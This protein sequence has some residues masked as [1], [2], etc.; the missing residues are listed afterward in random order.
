MVWRGNRGGSRGGRFS[1]RRGNRGRGSNVTR[2]SEGVS[3]P[4]PRLLETDV[5]IT[6]YLRSEAGFHG[7]IKSRYLSMTFC[8]LYINTVRSITFVCVFRYSDFHV[9]EISGDGTVAK[10]TDISVPVPP[11]SKSSEIEDEELNILNK[12]DTEV[13]SVEQ[14]DQI[15]TAAMAS[16]KSPEKVEV[17][18]TLKIFLFEKKYFYF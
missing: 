5:G 8:I 16:P 7:L 12:Y 6:E 18:L 14:W 1:N 11:N 2:S 13:L 3:N 9:S 17:R 15:N 4:G 10:L